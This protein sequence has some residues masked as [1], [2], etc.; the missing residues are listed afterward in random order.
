MRKIFPILLCLCALGLGACSTINSRIEERQDV[1][2]RLDPQAQSRIRQ[3]LIDVGYTPDMVY[4]ALGKPDRQT[5]R[6][7]SNGHEMTW[8]YKEYWEQYE[9]SRMVGYRR[10]VYFDPVVKA[11]RIYYE[12]VRAELYSEQ[13]EERT[14]VQFRNGVVIAIEQMKE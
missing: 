13:S 9:G 3:G 10:H 1:F 11:Y 8:I 4:I 7:T 5:D 6:T 2:N 12:P 14:R